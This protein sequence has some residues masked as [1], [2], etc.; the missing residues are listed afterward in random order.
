MPE[1]RKRMRVKIDSFARLHCTGGVFNVRTANISLK[2]VLLS[3]VVEVEPG[4]ECRLKLVLDSGVEM[5]FKVVVKRIDEAGTA[6]SF[7]SM[8]EVSFG[9]LRNFIKL[10]AE[11]ADAVDRELFSHAFKIINEADTA[12][13]Y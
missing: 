9:H 7:V 6:L 8:D 4:E 10:H 1:S 12:A 3:Q 5:R 13:E 2:G 11:D